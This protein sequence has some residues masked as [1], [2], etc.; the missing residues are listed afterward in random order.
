MNDRIGYWLVILIIIYTMSIYWIGIIASLALLLALKKA[1]IEGGMAG[2]IAFFVN[3]F[4]IF[5]I[6]VILFY[7]LL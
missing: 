6:I 3:I 2:C 1:K 5:E 7:M 4:L